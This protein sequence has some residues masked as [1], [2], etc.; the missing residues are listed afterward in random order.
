MMAWSIIH[1]GG[2]MSEDQFAKGSASVVSLTPDDLS[3]VP[4]ISR[5][6]FSRRN[7]TR[8]NFRNR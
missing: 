3:K 5:A 4:E 8:A 6:T 1:D 2:R 7:I